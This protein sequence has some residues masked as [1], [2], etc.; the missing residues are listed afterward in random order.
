MFRSTGTYATPH[1]SKYLQQLCK[2]FAHK[3]EVT[4]DAAQGQVA[5][6]SGPATLRADDQGLTVTVSAPDAEALPG[7]RHAIDK[8]LA[9]FA[10]REGFQAMTWTPGEA[11]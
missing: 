1:G 3:T 5:L 4:F 6:R 9:I 11:A 10:H 7:A 2:H 8:H